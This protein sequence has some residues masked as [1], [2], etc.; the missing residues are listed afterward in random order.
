MFSE[1]R[2]LTIELVARMLMALILLT[3]GTSKFFS[4]GGF[5]EYYAGQFGNEALRITLPGALTGLYLTVIPFIEVGLG[6]AL[7]LSMFKPWTIY[8]WYAFMASLL[9]GHYILQEWSEVNQ[10]LDYFF[11][12][13]V[14]HL[15]PT[16]TISRFRQAE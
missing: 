9:V 14:C 13:F 12:G 4:G 16:F 15:L 1:K 11:L 6:L 7:L 10:M 2:L 3:A 5:A 8:A